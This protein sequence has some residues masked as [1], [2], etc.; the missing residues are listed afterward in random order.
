MIGDQLS[1]KVRS[2]ERG[3]LDELRGKSV[4]LE[5]QVCERELYALRF[6]YQ[7][8]LGEHLRGRL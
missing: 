6:S 5:V 7:S 2:R 4:I 1:G 8:H 3:K